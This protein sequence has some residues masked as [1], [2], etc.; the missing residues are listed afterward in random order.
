MELRLNRNAE[1]V[2]ELLYN[3]IVLGQAGDLSELMGR[4]ERYAKRFQ[5]K[6]YISEAA[7]ADWY[8]GFPTNRDEQPE[9][10]F[11]PHY[12]VKTEVEAQSKDPAPTPYRF[13]EGPFISQQHAVEAA[14]KISGKPAKLVGS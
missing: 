13:V 4:A 10:F 14:F 11:D 2:Y 12:L 9:I 5:K 3:D 7:L 6:L 8:V 1:N